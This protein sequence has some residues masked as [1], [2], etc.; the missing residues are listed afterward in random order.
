VVDVR[1]V[2]ALAYASGTDKRVHPSYM[3]AT[4]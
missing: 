3:V 4:L 1:D 2:A